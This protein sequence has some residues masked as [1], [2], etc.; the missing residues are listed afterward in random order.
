MFR[1]AAG[2]A[3][4]TLPI[5]LDSSYEEETDLTIISST[6][7]STSS[8]PPTPQQN[9]SQSQEKKPKRSRN[10]LDHV[11]EATE[12][13]NKILE[14]SIETGGKEIGFT[15]RRTGYSQNG[16]NNKIEGN[17]SINRNSKKGSRTTTWHDEDISGNSNQIVWK[18]TS[19]RVASC[20]NDLR[21]YNHFMQNNLPGLAEWL[22]NL[23]KKGFHTCMC[24]HSSTILL[25]CSAV[26]LEI[27]RYIADLRY[28]E[29]WI[30]TSLSESTNANHLV[31]L[32]EC[33][34]LFR[35]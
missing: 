15:E 9:K 10:L 27:V 11:T 5:S 26:Q 32:V 20:T 24:A 25:S 6:S 14:K 4:S 28:K 31:C 35:N 30:K 22:E 21:L 33:L 34:T 12:E 23:P 8:S 3:L 1:E 16:G 29:N 2:R 13:R 19:M 7:S 17:R 18:E